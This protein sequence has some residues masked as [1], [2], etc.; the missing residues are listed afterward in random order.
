MTVTATMLPASAFHHGPAFVLFGNTNAAMPV[1]W[2][3]RPFRSPGWQHC[4][5]IKPMR[6]GSVVVNGLASV[7]VI[8]WSEVPAVD[9]VAAMLRQFPG[10]RVL[11]LV[12]QTTGGVYSPFEPM[13]CVTAVKAALGIRAPWVVSPRG[14]YEL[15]ARRGAERFG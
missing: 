2:W 9:C 8:E 12:D 4:L 6:Q 3:W 15:L 10:L 5:L 11:M 13:T 14:L 1:R 7:V